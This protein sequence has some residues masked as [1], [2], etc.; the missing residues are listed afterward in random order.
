MPH[1]SRLAARLLLGLVW[2]NVHLAA[3][4]SANEAY[5]AIHSNSRV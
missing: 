3:L 1:M 2:V 4:S 5:W